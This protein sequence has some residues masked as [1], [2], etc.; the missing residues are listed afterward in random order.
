[1][2]TFRQEYQLVTA[3]L[4]YEDHQEELLAVL[5]GAMQLMSCFFDKS[6]SL[7]DLWTSINKISNVSAATAQLKTVNE[8]ISL[9]RIWFNR[10]SVS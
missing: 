1:M 8:E 9:I 2:E 4:L 6:C 3:D 5:L 7:L 10:V